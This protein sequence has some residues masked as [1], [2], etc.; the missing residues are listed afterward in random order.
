MTDGTV[1]LRVTLSL[2]PQQLERLRAIFGVDGQDLQDTLGELASAALTEYALAFSGTRAPS[3]MREA[4]ELRLRLLY[5]FLSGDRPT[6]D[7]IG[8]LFQL[9]PAQAGTLIAGTRA[10]FSRELGERLRQ[11]A[12]QA[13]RDA[14]PVDE[15]TVRIRVPDSLARYMKELVART[16]APPLDKRRDASQT[17]DL[18][19]STVTALCEQLG[20]DP[21]VV[22]ALDWS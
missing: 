18:T 10:R 13:L 14:R 22:Q 11:A 6:D 2:D 20:E 16:T 3:T 17:Y 4:R 19:R 15:D 9:T 8:A 5:E 21:Q 12:A 7:Q 1:D